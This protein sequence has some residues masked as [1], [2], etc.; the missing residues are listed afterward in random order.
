MGIIVL[1][2]MTGRLKCGPKLLKVSELLLSTG[3]AL[4][5]AVHVAELTGGNCQI[6]NSPNT[7]HS[8]FVV[9]EYF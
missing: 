8:N 6:R 3:C 1:P 5:K 4:K 7:C 9:I 2:S